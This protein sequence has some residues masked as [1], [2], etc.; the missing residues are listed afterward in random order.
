[1]VHEMVVSIFSAYDL[2]DLPID[3]VIREEA[4][5]MWSALK[6]LC[7]RVAIVDAR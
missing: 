3:L 1:M 4:G 5:M 7:S 2:T 6:G